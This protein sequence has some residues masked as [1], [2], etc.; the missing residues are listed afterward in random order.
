[1]VTCQDDP[2][3]KDDKVVKKYALAL[4]LLAL[5]S[6]I[7]VAAAK[8]YARPVSAENPFGLDYGIH[9]LLYATKAQGIPT[10]QLGMYHAQ[11]VFAGDQCKT[12]DKPTGR[13]RGFRTI[14]L[15]D[16]DKDLDE[17]YKLA[18]AQVV[19]KFRSNYQHAWEGMDETRRTQYCA[20]Y[21]AD[22]GFRGQ[23]KA[24]L[25][26]TAFHLP[27]YG[28]LS[29]FYLAAL[30]PISSE[31]IEEME[32]KAKA[33]EKEEKYLRAIV[34]FGQ[35]LTLA[36]GFSAGNDAIAA[37]KSGNFSLSQMRF[38]QAGSLLQISGAS[39][40]PTLTTPNVDSQ[41][42]PSQPPPPAGCLALDHFDLYDA[43]PDSDVWKKYQSLSSDCEAL[44]NLR[45]DLIAP[46]AA[47]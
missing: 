22:F 39:V 7:A 21:W 38:A 11:I 24:P 26:N 45:V 9:P 30:S 19:E 32:R 5:N 17:P 29:Q 20:G 46:A 10:Y 33:R 28:A 13:Q 8:K 6:T 31:S 34:L 35:V 37:G 2:P 15:W 36:A 41:A 16:H 23:F 14:M 25:I 18:Y 1:M 40:L 27:N 47:P 42:A 12:T 3:A 4:L 44:D 43:E